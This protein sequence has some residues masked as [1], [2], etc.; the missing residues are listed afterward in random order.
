LTAAG[1]VAVKRFEDLS[2]SDNE[3]MALSRVKERLRRQFGVKRLALF[4]SLA[5]GEADEES[6]VDLLVLTSRPLNRAER[7]LITDLVCDVNLEYGTNLST[8]VIDEESWERGLVSLLPIRQ[9]IEQDG[10]PL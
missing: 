3:R 9:A 4:G 6:D 10:V 8:L 2:L 5:R 7:H 1:V